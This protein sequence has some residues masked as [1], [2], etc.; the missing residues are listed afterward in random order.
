MHTL[1]NTF[2][3]FDNMTQNSTPNWRHKSYGNHFPDGGID[4]MRENMIWQSTHFRILG[5]LLSDTT[6]CVE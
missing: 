3:L 4:I 6:F 5:L 1:L 2:K